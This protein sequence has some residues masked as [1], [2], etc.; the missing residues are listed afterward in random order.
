MQRGHTIQHRF[1]SPQIRK[2]PLR[3]P[4]FLAGGESAHFGRLFECD[5]TAVAVPFGRVNRTSLLRLIVA[6]D[7]FGGST[8]GKVREDTL[9]GS[10]ERILITDC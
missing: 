2:V 3:H 10:S 4:A 8:F 9:F 6:V 5:A 1:A 7:L